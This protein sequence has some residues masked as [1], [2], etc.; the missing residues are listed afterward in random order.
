MLSKPGYAQLAVALTDANG[1]PLDGLK[2]S[3]FAV[4]SGPNPDQIVYFRQESSV[5]T[6]V[7]LVIVGDVSES[8]Y[9]KT[10]VTSYDDLYK[11]HSAL[12]QA[13]DALNQCDEVALVTIG[14]EYQPDPSDPPW[15]IEPRL[16]AVT[17]AQSFTTDQSLALQK[18]YSVKPSGEKRLSDGLRMGLDTLAG[19][20]YPNRAL[21]LMTDGLDQAAIDQSAPVLA[22]LRESGVSFWVVG[23]GDPDAQEGI[24]TKLRGTT[25]L[26]TGAVKKLAADGGGWVVFSQPVDSDQGASL[27]AAVPTI[28]KEL[29]SGYAL[30]VDQPPG[31]TAPVVTLANNSAVVIRANMVPSAVL[32]E[33]AARPAMPKHEVE[34][35]K[36]IIA[37]AAIRNA[38]GYTEI[39]ATVAKPDG[40]YV[41]G[42]S[43]SDFKL[44]VN[45]A[46]LPIDFFRAGEESPA[47][48]GILVDTSGSMIPKLPQ[49]R[50]AI[51]QFVKTLDP[52]DDVFL[53]AFSNKPY[54]LQPLT[55]DHQ[56][57][58]RQLDSLHAY[59]QTALFDTIKQGISEID[60]SHN[61]RKVLLVITDGMDNTSS[62]T[63]DEVVQAAKS[64]G[65]IVY[66][67][68]IG[69]P[70]GSTPGPS[71]SIGPFV[72][73]GDDMEQVD[74]V[75]LSRLAG[76][77]GGKSYII[78][79][80]GDGVALKKACA[81]IE[82]DLGDRRSYAI[83]FIAKTPADYAPTT[84][85]ISLQVPA[86]HDYVVDAPNWI[87]APS[88]PAQ[89][90]ISA[91]RLYAP[92]PPS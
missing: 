6:P 83:G 26:D 44:S 21:V 90:T 2:K 55:H 16:G 75:T 63:A 47:T 14:G 62:A 65:V 32:A 61:Q 40:D 74:T 50:A 3:D 34:T 92:R 8:M 45:G 38:A 52:Q 59:G 11:A 76:A 29:G 17:L 69:N 68:G 12:S 7:S 56:A 24:L 36:D 86:H 49:A 57:V 18:M 23:I 64:S 15:S 58:I 27:A 72:M 70:N 66:S 43:K 71:I 9:C 13:E 67:I 80:I 1:A 53:F 79:E 78:Q 46:P 33:A 10:I 41:E 19:A 30:G 22:Q 88:T 39:A 87:P 4:R 54:R 48:V 35:A 31:A 85:P 28:S 81:E 51:E 77:N 84:M 42:L 37:P 5:A 20:H 89:A 82:H 91:N 60:Q 25:R 73:G